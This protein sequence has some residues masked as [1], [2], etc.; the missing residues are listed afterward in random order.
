MDIKN[1]NYSG[2]TA[3]QLLADDFFIRSMVSPTPETELFWMLLSRNDSALSAEITMAMR[4]LDLL[5]E[6]ES[7]LSKAEK[8][9]LWS[10]INDTN[11]S[12]IEKHKRKRF[13]AMRI[14]LATAMVAAVVMFGI[15][16]LSESVDQSL[17]Y[18]EIA[19]ALSEGNPSDQ[20]VLKISSD[21]SIA[22]E[23]MNTSIEYTEKGAIKANNDIVRPESES[24]PKTTEMELKFNQLT[25]PRSKRS[26]LTLSD[27]TQIWVNSGSKLIYPEVFAKEKR[28]I[29]VEGEVYLEVSKDPVRPFIVKTREMDISVLGTCFD[30]SAYDGRDQ[31]VVLA[32]GKVSIETVGQ[33]TIVIE[34][35][36]KL[37]YNGSV[38]VEQVDVYDYIAW[39]D[40]FY[41]I[42]NES[43]ADILLKVSQYYGVGLNVDL[44]NLKNKTF[45]GMLVFNDDVNQ[46]IRTL[47]EVLEP[48]ASFS[49]IDNNLT[50]NQ[51]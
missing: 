50:I 9:E 43:I 40:G 42:H 12:M 44:S 27:G 46:V 34:P 5:K 26:Q 30:V 19:Q 31:F 15:F 17:D 18:T 28:E 8:S 45:S 37:S 29:Y 2:Y 48:V 4:M 21:S 16:L 6:T 7:P 22:F 49:L 10:W 36:Q 25:V 51:Y 35:G 32:E 11:V 3:D 24:I 33:K 13:Y 39:K 20:V 1:K 38:S 41:I 47:N 14:A 23:G